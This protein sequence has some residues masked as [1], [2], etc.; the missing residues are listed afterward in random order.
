M[1]IA[2]VAAIASE[3]ISTMVQRLA[4]ALTRVKLGYSMDA[5]LASEIVVFLGP[6]LP[7]KRQAFIA[8]TEDS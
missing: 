6:V 8:T 3:V 4:R 1:K 7:S 2:V 5:S